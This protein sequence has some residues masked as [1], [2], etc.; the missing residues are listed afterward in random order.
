M[1]LNKTQRKIQVLLNFVVF[2]I[3][4]SVCFGGAISF[5]YPDTITIKT[6]TLILIS[7]VFP[8]AS[9][10]ILEIVMAIAEDLKE[11]NNG[12]TNNFHGNE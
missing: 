10:I 9:P 12:K 4:M 3:A 11:K 1:K 7:I 5:C 8:F 2:L 6:D